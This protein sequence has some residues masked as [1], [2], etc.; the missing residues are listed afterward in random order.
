M[1]HPLKSDTKTLKE[2]GARLRAIRTDR[3]L[4]QVELAEQV[5][6][7]QVII[8]DYERGVL[9][10]YHDMIARFART[11]KVSAD[12]LLGLK[13]FKGNGDANIKLM[14]R[15]KQIEALPDAQQ[16][17]LLKTIDTFIKGAE[18]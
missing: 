18:R 13:P 7:I 17:V 11:L 15:L 3:G 16:K 2:F 1:G 8:S 6:V 14:R 10:P 9:R 5:G 4:T 12:E